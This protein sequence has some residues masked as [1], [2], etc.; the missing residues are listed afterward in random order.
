MLPSIVEGTNILAHTRTPIGEELAT[1]QHIVLSYQ[2]EWNLHSVQFPKAIQ[3]VEE[4]IEYR[5]SISYI[6]SAV[7]YD[8]DNEEDNI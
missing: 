3:S 4:E 5:R 8:D 2:H 7:L 1:C 6:S